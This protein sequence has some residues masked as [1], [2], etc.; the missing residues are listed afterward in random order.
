MAFFIIVSAIVLFS[1]LWD[2]T[3]DYR[4]KLWMDLQEEFGV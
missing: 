2:S 1:V 3:E 4:H